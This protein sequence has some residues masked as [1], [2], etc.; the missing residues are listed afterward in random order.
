M[1]KVHELFYQESSERGCFIEL[2]DSR[3]VFSLPKQPLQDL[4]STQQAGLVPLLLATC[5]EA[6]AVILGCLLLLTTAIVTTG[7][8]AA[9]S[10]TDHGYLPCRGSSSESCNTLAGIARPKL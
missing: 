4:G 7:I 3:E 10:G 5:L 1:E 9:G 8:G 2:Q 6:P